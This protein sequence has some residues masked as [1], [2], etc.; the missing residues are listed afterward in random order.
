MD[1]EY[2]KMK[3]Y[4]GRIIISAMFI[5]GIILPSSLRADPDDQYWH[6]LGNGGSSDGYVEDLIAAGAFSSI[7]GTPANNIARWNGTGWQPLG[8]GAE[9]YEYCL[10]VSKAARRRTARMQQM[11]ISIVRQMSA[12]PCI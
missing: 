6:D 1:K 2:D 8:S 7:G 9:G 10:T 4:A 3:T 5:L 11:P 12:T